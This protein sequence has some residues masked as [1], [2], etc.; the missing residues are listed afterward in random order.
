MLRGVVILFLLLSFPLVKCF[1][2]AY[3][4][5]A[6]PTLSS[7]GDITASVPDVS[8]LPVEADDIHS[9]VP[10]MN[11]WMSMFSPDVVPAISNPLTTL[12]EQTPLQDNPSKSY[13][14]LLRFPEFDNSNDDNIPA[15]PDVGAWRAAVK[16]G[17]ID[18]PPSIDAYLSGSVQLQPAHEEQVEKMWMNIRKRASL[19]NLDEADKDRVIGA[20]RIAYVTLYGKTTLRSLEVAVNRAH[21]TA[22]V[23]GELKAGVNVVI[24]GILHAVFADATTPVGPR[25]RAELLARF[26]KDVIELVE[27][28]ARLPRFMTGAVEYTPLQSENQ[29]QMLVSA[30]DEY[31]V[32]LIRIAERLHQ[33][34]VLRSLPLMETDRVKLAEEALYVYAPLAHKMGL[35]KI[36]GELEDLAFRTINPVMFQQT[37]YTQTA[38]N[39]AF[40]EAADIIESLVSKDEFMTAH[41]ATYKLTYRIK[42]KYQ[43]YLKMKRK[44]LKNTNQVRD[45]LG[46]RLIIKTPID[47]NRNVE[48]KKKLERDLCYHLVSKLRIMPGWTPAERGFKDY[49][50]NRKSNGYQSLHQY[51]RNVALG[52]NVEVQVR[53]QEMHN[54]AELGEAAHWYYKDQIYRPE[55]A[56]SK[57]YRLA[58]RSPQQAQSSSAEELMT[59]AKRQLNTARVFVYLHDCSTVLNL[60]ADATALDAAMSIHSDV[61]LSA[62]AINLNGKRVALNKGLKNGDVIRV[63]RALAGVVTALPSWLYLSKCPNTH[64]ILRKYFRDHHRDRIVCHGLILLCAAMAKWLPGK[65]PK[66]HRLVSL[67]RGKSGHGDISSF[68]LALGSASKTDAHSMLVHL[69]GVSKEMK[70][71]VIPTAI[72]WGRKQQREAW[73]EKEIKAEELLSLQQSLLRYVLPEQGLPLAEMRWC[74]LLHATYKPVHKATVTPFGYR[75]SLSATMTK[76]KPTSGTRSSRTSVSDYHIHRRYGKSQIAR[77]STPFSLQAASLPP[78]LLRLAKQNIALKFMKQEERLKAYVKKQ[79]VKEFITQKPE[80]MRIQGVVMGMHC[81]KVWKDSIDTQ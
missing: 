70:S 25:F 32:L 21:G 62:V 30:S 63:E 54:E 7:S 15:L 12:G 41:R 78:P 31:S 22:S 53:S 43:L 35:I 56:N 77:A 48:E 49:I 59:L 46:L 75:R 60:R 61:G 72:A 3:N 45:A 66:T 26:G 20:L 51:I 74:D 67:V 8:T 39:K 13:T 55:V 52:S 80:V 14:D 76:N 44:N 64:A 37:K 19:C 6:R 40:H 17:G 79:P 27:K 71:I 73:K 57:L 68:L 4:V 38:A 47:K 50:K 34:R 10:K 42:G 65:V 33:M 36:K 58:W 69:L 24:A 81:G 29:I 2:I 18:L 16:T 1:N 9:D 11:V 23:L 28:Y 5:I